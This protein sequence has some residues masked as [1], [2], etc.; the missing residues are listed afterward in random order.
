MLFGTVSVRIRDGVQLLVL[1][2]K[3]CVLVLD[4]SLAMASKT[5]GL[6]S[7]LSA[8]TSS[9]DILASIHM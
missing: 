2:D 6:G 7:G 9:L 8:L 4:M 1:E 5:T 3:K